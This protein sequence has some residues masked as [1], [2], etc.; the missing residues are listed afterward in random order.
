MVESIWKCNSIS[1]QH[2]SI[3]S[4]LS[5]AVLSIPAACYNAGNGSNHFAH[6]VE[7]GMLSANECTGPTMCYEHHI[8][9][10]SLMLTPF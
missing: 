5:A 9:T 10:T 8:F 2:F 7:H 6:K 3:G 4:V 1:V